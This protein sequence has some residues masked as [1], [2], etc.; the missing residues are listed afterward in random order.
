MV[1]LDLG[2]LEY[3]AVLGGLSHQFVPPLLLVQIILHHQGHQANLSYQ[4]HL[5]GPWALENLFVQV[6]QLPLT[7]LAVLEDL[8]DQCPL[9]F[10]DILL[11]PQDHT[12]PLAQGNQYYLEVLLVLVG[13]E[14]HSDH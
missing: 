12:P 3:P 7:N 2:A 5:S 9:Y 11:V 8:E 6:V 14:Y 13:Q 1:P 4:V 10:P